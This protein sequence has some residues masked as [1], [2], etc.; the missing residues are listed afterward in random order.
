MTDLEKEVKE[1]KFQLKA[2]RN[3]VFKH[4]HKIEIVGFGESETSK[5]KVWVE[6]PNGRKEEPADE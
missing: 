5:P 4:H 6:Y 1:L 3:F 2:L